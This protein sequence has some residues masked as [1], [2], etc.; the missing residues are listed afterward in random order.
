MTSLE[1]I[2]KLL[3]DFLSAKWCLR[4]EKFTETFDAFGRW[5]Y[6]TPQEPGVSWEFAFGKS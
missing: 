4:N 1:A 6:V 3:E 2:C 5:R